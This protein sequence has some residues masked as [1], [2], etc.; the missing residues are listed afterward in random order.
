M[1][2]TSSCDAHMHHAAGN[3]KRD[4]PISTSPLHRIDFFELIPCET[5]TQA[6]MRPILAPGS[7][8]SPVKVG[9]HQTEMKLRACDYRSVDIKRVSFF[10]F[11]SLHENADLLI[12]QGQCAG[13]VV[14][15]EFRAALESGVPGFRH[16]KNI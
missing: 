11:F 10:L 12:G 3:T 5:V 7:Q 9:G 15:H 13:V 16:S 14:Q 4:A 1:D 6:T 8:F 2:S